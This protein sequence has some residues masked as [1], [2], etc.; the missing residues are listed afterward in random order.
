MP[1]ASRRV[2]W[3]CDLLDGAPSRARGSRSIRTCPA[4]EHPDAHPDAPRAGDAPLACGSGIRASAV[5]TA[6]MACAGLGGMAAASMSGR[7]SCRVHGLEELVN[8]IRS[9]SL[10]ELQPRL[11][12][13]HDRTIAAVD[14]GGV[15]LGGAAWH[16]GARH[17]WGCDG[18]GGHKRIAPARA[19]ILAWRRGRRRPGPT[20]GRPRS[21]IASW[22]R[23]PS[24]AAARSSVGP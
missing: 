23:V 13:H 3:R 19:E 15:E 11:R 17:K 24:A 18:S 16:E 2:S 6:A 8:I 20:V 12:A 5:G 14:T 22:S 21:P 10:V 9:E 1:A 7:V 4:T